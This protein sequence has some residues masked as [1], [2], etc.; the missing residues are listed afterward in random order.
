MEREIEM[1]KGSGEH[2]PSPKDKPERPLNGSK[3]AE[4]IRKPECEK[5]HITQDGKRKPQS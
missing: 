3:P 5:K 1:K 2:Q 4:I